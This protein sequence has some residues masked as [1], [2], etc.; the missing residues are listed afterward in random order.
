LH[1][2]QLAS[3]HR[4]NS[5]AHASRNHAPPHPCHSHLGLRASHKL[6]VL[7]Q[8]QQ[9]QQ[10]QQRQRAIMLGDRTALVLQARRRASSSSGGNLVGSRRPPGGSRHARSRSTDSLADLYLPVTPSELLE[11]VL[12]EA[13]L[14]LG[15]AFKLWRYLGLGECLLCA[16]VL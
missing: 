11:R 1:A 7:P 8:Q 15:L 6:P 14:V 3:L 12:S 5:L 4:A 16:C 9:Q 10:Q 2:A 13:W